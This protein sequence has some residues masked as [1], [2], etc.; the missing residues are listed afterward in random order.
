MSASIA[1][2]A[3]ASSSPFALIGDHRAA[4][5]GEQEDAEDRLAVDFFVALADLDVALESRRGVDELRGGAGVQAELVLD[6]D[7]A[8]DHDARPP[9]SAASS[10]EATRIAFEPSR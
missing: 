9:S 10:S 4:A 1:S 7:V 2:T 5:G 3:S 6:L 8:L